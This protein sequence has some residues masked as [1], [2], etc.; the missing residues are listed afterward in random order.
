VYDRA[1]SGDEN[2]VRVLEVAGDIIGI[3]LNN[4]IHVMNPE[5]IVLGGGVLKAERFLMPRIKQEIENRALT[6][7]AKQTTITVSDL[8]DD[9]TLLGAISLFLV[10]LFALQ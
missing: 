9:A 4:V 3:A 8:G 5:K 7:D 10:E 1:V 2:C 6:P